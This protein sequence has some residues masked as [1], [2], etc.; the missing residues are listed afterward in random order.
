MNKL[1]DALVKT[2]RVLVGEIDRAYGGYI[3]G[4][5]RSIQIIGVSFAIFMMLGLLVLWMPLGTFVESES[6]WSK[7][8]MKLIPAQTIQNSEELKAL[9]NVKG[10]DF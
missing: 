8:F 5:R 4:E 7:N 10:Q 9:T 3:E 6:T 1:L 2:T